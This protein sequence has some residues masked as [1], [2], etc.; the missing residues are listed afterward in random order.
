M[1]NTETK[2]KVDVTA[3]LHKGLQEV[4]QDFFNEYGVK[5]HD[6]RFEWYE[7]LDGKDKVVG[8]RIESSRRADQ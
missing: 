5:L 8:I 4:A 7:M 3:I 6:I 1:A 2:V